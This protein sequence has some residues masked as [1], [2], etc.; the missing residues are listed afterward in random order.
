MCNYKWCTLTSK[1][2]STTFTCHV[3]FSHLLLTNDTWRL[4]GSI[5]KVSYETAF[6]ISTWTCH[7]FQW[8]I[9]SS[10]WHKCV[11]YFIKNL[12]MLNSMV[13]K[14]SRRSKEI[15]HF[16][17]MFSTL[18]KLLIFELVCLPGAVTH[19]VFSESYHSFHT[20]P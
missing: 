8:S 11:T 20:V 5:L 4:L 15:H 6:E 18:Y 13:F 7:L 16:T 19:W 2:G 1:Q 3:V 10:I 17:I 14:C 9:W 12:Q